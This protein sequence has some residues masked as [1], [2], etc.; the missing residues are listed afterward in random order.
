[1]TRAQER[2]ATFVEMIV[3]TSAKC[4]APLGRDMIVRGAFAVFVAQPLSLPP[5]PTFDPLHLPIWI[6]EQ[7]SIPGLPPFDQD[8]PSGQGARA[9][10]VRSIAWLFEARRYEGALLGLRDPGE[11]LQGVL[12]RQAPTLDLAEWPAIFVPVWNLDGDTM[13]FLARRV[14]LVPA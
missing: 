6:P 3:A 8:P 7:Q 11:P 13:A 12:E 9:T 14:P 5:G 1:M 10:R 4:R 2:L